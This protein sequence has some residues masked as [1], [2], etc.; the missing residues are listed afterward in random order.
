MPEQGESTTTPLDPRERARRR[1]KEKAGFYGHF[2]VF[3]VTI[4]FLALVN[5]MTNPHHLWFV[6]PLAGWGVGVMFHFLGTFVLADGSPL[7]ERM[8]EREMRYAH[9]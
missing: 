3:A 9:H 6:Y 4:G 5:L 8:I 1:V 2:A 7:Q